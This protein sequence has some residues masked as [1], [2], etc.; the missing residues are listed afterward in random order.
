MWKH[1]VTELNEQ[2]QES[3]CCEITVNTVTLIFTF[4]P[5][6]LVLSKILYSPTDA[7][8]SCLKNNIK[9]YIKIYITT[10]ATCFGVTKTNMGKSS[11]FRHDSLRFENSI[12][13]AFDTLL[14][15]TDLLY[16]AT[17]APY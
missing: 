16:A 9:I 4:V 13:A 1:S 14:F 3:I 17:L 8:V 7:L 6:V 15:I 5:C 2:L 12:I 10:A 11:Q